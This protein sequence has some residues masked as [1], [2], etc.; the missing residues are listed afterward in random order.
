[1]APKRF[2]YKFFDTTEGE[3][4]L[5][6]IVDAADMG[7]ALQ[8]ALSLLSRHHTT[9]KVEIERAGTSHGYGLGHLSRTAELLASDCHERASHLF[10]RADQEN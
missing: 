8:K 7:E 10:A 3:R 5:L 2:T 1:M 4:Q 6:G 9:T